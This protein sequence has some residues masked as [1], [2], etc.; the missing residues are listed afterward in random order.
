MSRASELERSK[1]LMMRMASAQEKMRGEVKSKAQ[2]LKQE[3][4][5]YV[6]KLIR[7]KENSFCT[8]CEQLKK[9]K[10]LVRNPNSDIQSI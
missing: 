8:S 5:W 1:D 10:P 2:E 3:V 6:S 7:S 9:S 4:V